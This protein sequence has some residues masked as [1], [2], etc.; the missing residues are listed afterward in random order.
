MASQRHNRAKYDIGLA[1]LAAGEWTSDVVIG[2]VYGANG[3]PIG[4]LAKSGYRRLTVMVAGVRYY[5]QA[6]C[7]L[8]EAQHGPIPGGM[9]V[10]HIN[11]HKA[12]NRAVN[13]ELVTPSGNSCHALRVGL[14]VADAGE[15]H[16][17][18]TLAD[19]EV[20]EIRRRAAD[21][22]SRS[23]LARTFGVTPQ[24]VGRIVRG[25]QRTRTTPQPSA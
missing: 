23:G 24:H 20:L 6:H 7:L 5:L 4:Y 16:G 15:Q 8:W 17:S 14:K 25:Q 10:N 19:A 18:A 21:G 9:E 1:K 3:Q 11:G 22:Q 13:L 12:Y 2:Q